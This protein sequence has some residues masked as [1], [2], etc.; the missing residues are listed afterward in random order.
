MTIIIAFASPDCAPLYHDGL[1]NEV[2]RLRWQHHPAL[3]DRVD[4]RVSRYLKAQCSLRYHHSLSHKKGYSVLMSA[5]LPQIRLGVDLEQ[6][7]HR[8]FAALLPLFTRTE[9]RRWWQQQADGHLAFYQ[10][11][12]LKEALIKANNLD[13]PSDL[14]SVGLYQNAQGSFIAGTASASHDF[15]WSCSWFIAPPNWIICAVWQGTDAP[16]RWQCYGQQAQQMLPWTE[17]KL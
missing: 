10:L 1:L 3:S 5:L 15:G 16:L 9:E 12:T 7:C 6:C 4:W 14:Q 13:F 17:I 11:W 2:D 8:D